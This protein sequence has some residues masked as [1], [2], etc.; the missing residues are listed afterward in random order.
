M[1]MLAS[2]AARVAV[3]RYNNVVIIV[4][5]L[6]TRWLCSERYRLWAARRT[7]L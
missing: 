7:G 1:G 6:L 4:S 3:A 2:L 5:P